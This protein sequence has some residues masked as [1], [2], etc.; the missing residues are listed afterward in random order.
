[1]RDDEQIG[2]RKGMPDEL[3]SRIDAALRSYVQPPEPM[4]P[5][6]AMAVLME[7]AQA[8]RPPHGLRWWMYG[9]AGVAAAC[10]VAVIFA[11]WAF[12]APQALGIAST[13]KPP[14]AVAV[15]PSRVAVAES[16]ASAPRPTSHSNRTSASR[17]LA[18]KATPL[19]KLDV[20]PSPKPL[21]PE[22]QALVDFAKRGPPEVQRAVLEDQKH[23]DDPIIVADL[24]SHP[25]QSVSQQNR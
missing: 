7:R 23:W 19:P 24:Q 18:A 21:S 12:R 10:L 5:R 25:P 22:E 2:G 1:M 16:P 3:D 17:E 4:A 8:E 14:L 9:I 15:P 13:P 20:F 11:V 6:I